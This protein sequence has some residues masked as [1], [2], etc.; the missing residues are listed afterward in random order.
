MIGLLKHLHSDDTPGQVGAG[1]A[2]GAI[3]GLTPLLN[4]HNV[5]VLIL[6]I[7]LR[8]S[9][10]GALLGWLL[11]TPLGFAF[12]P[13]F[14]AL[15]HRLLLETPALTGVWTTLYNTP[16]VPLTNFNNTVVLGSLAVALALFLPLNALGRFGVR[17]YRAAVQTWVRRHQPPPPPP[18][19]GT[20]GRGRGPHPL[21]G[22]GATPL[23]RRPAGER[24]A[25]VRRSAREGCVRIGRHRDRGG[26]SRGRPPAPGPVAR[27]GGAQRARGREP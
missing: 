16:V 12:D 23:V 18:T 17:R 4:L 21:A 14:D 2:M 22:D 3:L 19:P 5:V 10:S 1:L 26:E 7:M 8:V 15:G 9:F 27:Q 11:F 6:I 24:V 13:L 25:A 20:A